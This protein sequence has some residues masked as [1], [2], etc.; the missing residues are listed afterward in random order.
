MNW[1]KWKDGKLAYAPNNWVNGEL[2]GELCVSVDDEDG[3]WVHINNGLYVL[4]EVK[5]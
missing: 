1:Y 4:A 2:Q 3:H 5:E